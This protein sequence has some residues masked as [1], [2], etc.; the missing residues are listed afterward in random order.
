MRSFILGIVIL[1]AVP[2]YAVGQQRDRSGRSATGRTAV[3][4]EEAVQACSSE[5]DR[6]SCRTARGDKQAGTAR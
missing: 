4:R 6:S 3:P 5:A 2:E 1:M